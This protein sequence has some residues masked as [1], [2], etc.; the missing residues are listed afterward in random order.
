MDH[1]AFKLVQKCTRYK[2]YFDSCLKSHEYSLKIKINV[3][4]GVDPSP[5]IAVTYKKLTN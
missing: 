3:K 5:K 2:Y 4:L 1:A